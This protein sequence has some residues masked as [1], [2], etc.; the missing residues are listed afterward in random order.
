MRWAWQRRGIRFQAE[1]GTWIQ[2]YLG[3]SLALIG[4]SKP[5]RIRGELD[6]LE[7]QAIL[8]NTNLI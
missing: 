7:V 2:V 8:K 6:L 1:R 4:F 5:D 3:D